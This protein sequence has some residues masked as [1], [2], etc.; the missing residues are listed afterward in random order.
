MTSYICATEGTVWLGPY[1]Q[2][3]TGVSLDDCEKEC[4][5][6]TDCDQYMFVRNDTHTKLPNSCTMY[7]QTEK[8]STEYTLNLRRNRQVI[9][10]MGM[11]ETH[12]RKKTFSEQ[13][14]KPSK[15][16]ETFTGSYQKRDY[17]RK[18]RV[19]GHW[20]WAIWLILGLSV[21]VFGGL[22]VYMVISRSRQGQG[23]VPQIQPVQKRF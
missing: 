18:G 13:G 23:P 7:G 12:C 3:K 16:P 22:L 11:S 20:G 1:V 14:W 6:R 2:G 10:D 4:T 15:E 8:G 19:H 5:S 9:T 21:F 17:I